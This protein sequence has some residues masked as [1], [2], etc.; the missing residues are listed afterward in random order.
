MLDRAH[1]LATNHAPDDF[2]PPVWP[3]LPGRSHI[4]NLRKYTSDL[5]TEAAPFLVCQQACPSHLEE[6][7]HCIRAFQ[8]IKNFL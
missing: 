4:L 5:V 7:S 3:S 1:D 6:L 8:I 2:A